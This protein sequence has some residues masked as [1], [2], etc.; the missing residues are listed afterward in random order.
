MISF[1]NCGEIDTWARLDFV[2]YKEDHI[3]ILSVDEFQHM[4]YEIV[5]EVARMSKIMC[6]IRSSGDERHILWL[7]F[8]PDFFSC[9][10][11]PVRIGKT[12]REERIIQCIED[13]E[14]MIFK[15]RDISLYYLYYD[16]FK[17]DDEDEDDVIIPIVS[18][19]LEY[20]PQWA[21][22]ICGTIID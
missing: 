10:G 13:S 16:C 8:N 6:A 18:L 12:A 15:Q 2:I 3:I 9:N 5:C 4:D 22:L 1:R 11:E 17:D 21:E 19:S 7:R 14:K 20:D